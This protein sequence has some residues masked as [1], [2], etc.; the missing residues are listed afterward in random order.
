MTA[1]KQNIL[2][3]IEDGLSALN[4]TSICTCVPASGDLC[5]H[6][7][8]AMALQLAKQSLISTARKEIEI[9]TAMDEAQAEIENKLRICLNS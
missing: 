4:Q 7:K 6:C 9:A 2:Q 1:I 8:I 3:T 5:N